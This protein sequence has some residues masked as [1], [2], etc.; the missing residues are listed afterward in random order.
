MRCPRCPYDVVALDAPEL[1]FPAR[2]KAYECAWCGPVKAREKALIVSW[3]KPQ[4]FV[5]L[6]NAPDDWQ[7]LRQ[8]VRTLAMQVRR[9]GYVWETAWSVERGKKTGMKHVH[10]L[11][12][13]SY[14]PQATLQDL[15]GWI[16]D[17]RAIKNPRGAV[18][19]ALKE[20]E[21]TTKYALKGTKDFR[22]HLQL[23]GG[24]VVH[25]SRKYLHGMRSDDV[26]ALL[27]TGGTPGPAHVWAVVGWD[28][29]V[30]TDGTRAGTYVVR[31]T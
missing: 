17:I 13:G 12:H 7:A 4:R 10:L 5:T 11:Q 31:G 25:L 1:R 14:V 6:T 2:C 26:L 19:Y 27:R 8:K 3:A 18:K 24:R 21:R 30:I 23:N 15:W 20:A 9:A 28:V 22:N 16:V 29:E